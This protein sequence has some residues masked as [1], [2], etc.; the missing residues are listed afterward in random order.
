[1]ECRK[2]KGLESNK[3]GSPANQKTLEEKKTDSHPGGKASSGQAQLARLPGPRTPVLEGPV[4]G[5]CFE[6]WRA[7]WQARGTGTGTANSCKSLTNGLDI[8][9]PKQIGHKLE[10]E[11][12][13]SCRQKEVMENNRL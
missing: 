7:K 8:V 4:G 5:Q 2:L 11:R 6:K 1:M 10:K 12:A 3:G 13:K 9:N